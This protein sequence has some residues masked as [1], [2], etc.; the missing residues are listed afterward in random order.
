MR[1]VSKFTAIFFCLAVFLLWNSCSNSSGGGSSESAVFSGGGT[2]TPIT[3]TYTITF[4][5]NDG[6]GSPATSTQTFTAG[7]SQALKTIS[8]LGFSKSGS[9]FAG[10]GTAANATTASYSDG[11]AY[12]A[13]ADATLYALWSTVPVYSVNIPVNEHGTITAS[14]TSAA[15]G[16][17]ITL[18]ISSSN[19]Y[20]LESIFVTAGTNSITVLGDGN[21]RTFTMPA[22]NVVVN[23]V[24]NWKW[25]GTK[26][27][28]AAREVGDI[29]FSDGSGME[30]TCWKSQ[31]GLSAEQ[32]KAVVAI[33]FDATNK[34]GVGLELTKKA[35]AEFGAS[36][37]NVVVPTSSNDG[38]Q[39]IDIIKGY[40]DY[41]NGKYPAF[42]W[43]DEFRSLES[44]YNSG[45]YLPAYVDVCNIYKIRENLCKAMSFN[46]YYYSNLVGNFLSS[47]QAPTS[48][49]RAQTLDFSTG[50]MIS[51]VEKNS[52]DCYVCAIRVF[53]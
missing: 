15:A 46:G 2:Q 28:T 8:D 42:K 33:I 30:V 23:A 26:S 53:N 48:N 9:N 35:W 39:N 27:P 34:L 7:T 29:I 6:S 32:K 50:G 47:T 17:E 22:G 4:N 16:T 25:L 38:K 20:K 14:F 45:W 49:T 51:S 31:T 19:N 41:N 11:A 43:A 21:T 18:S 1:I 40:S 13:T 36:A 37:W 5:A 3:A 52:V 44:T 10:W 24:F 12:T